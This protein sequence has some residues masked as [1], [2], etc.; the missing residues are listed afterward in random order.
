[1]HDHTPADPRGELAPILEAALWNLTQG[2]AGKWQFFLLSGR[3]W[4]T[5]GLFILGMLAGRWQ[6][7]VCLLYTS[8]CV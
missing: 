6:V 4:Q 8:R 5:L 3:I 2:Q 7:F 1:M